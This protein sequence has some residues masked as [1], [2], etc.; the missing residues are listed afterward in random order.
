[1]SRSREY[2]ISCPACGAGQFVDLYEAVNVA[3]DPQ[4]KNA[5][6]QNCLNRV[7]CADCGASFRVDMPL[8]YTDPKYNMM[9]HWMPESVEMP[10]DQIQEEFDRTLEQINEIVPDDVS[11][12]NVRLVLSRVELVEL[13][14]MLEAG[15]N[16]R[17]VEYV[18]YSIYT[19]NMEKVDPARHRLLLNVEDSTDEELCFVTQD[20]INHELGG[21]LRYGR[22]AYQS[23]CELYDESP[24]EFVE[25][26][27]GPCISARYLLLE[28]ADS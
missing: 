4:L 18:K 11:V 14:Y 10:R 13:I 27:P 2:N 3:D 6:M 20:T 12:P 5:L 28:E 23:M 22:P 15:Y 8:L 1:M 26:F 24:D 25:M 19:R 17:V 21:I 9:I 7:E 16:Q